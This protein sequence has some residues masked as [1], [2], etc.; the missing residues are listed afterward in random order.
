MSND[1]RVKALSDAEIRVIAATT[2]QSRPQYLSDGRV[3][4]RAFL[5]DTKLL[6]TRGEKTLIY[7]VRPDAQLGD[8]DARTSFALGLVRVTARLSVDNGA[9]FGMG[10]ERSTLAHELG[11]AVLHEGPPMARG[12]GAVGRSPHRYIESYRS[13]EHHAKVFAA[14]FLIDEQMAA[15]SKGPNDIS[16]RFGVSLEAARITWERLTEPK[17]R[18]ESY[19]RIDS[20]VD[21]YG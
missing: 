20:L 7:E 1:Y 9:K 6:T 3:D 13:A 18:R 17:R 4:V 14:A 5:F 8:D 2:R 15:K 16:T 19:E 10:R 12:Q 11:H 21:S